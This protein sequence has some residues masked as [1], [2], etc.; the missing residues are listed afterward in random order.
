MKRKQFVRYLV[1]ISIVGLL[2]VIS[3]VYLT[4]QNDNEI[5]ND[6]VIINN[7]LRIYIA[8][9]LHYL[10]P[11][12]YGDTDSFRQMNRYGDGKYM[13]QIEVILDTF[14]TQVLEDKP[15]VVVL[16]GDLTLNGEKRSHEVLA[17]KLEKL[18]DQ[19]IAVYVIPGNHDI[20]SKAA[21][22][23]SKDTAVQTQS[24]TKQ[25]FR[26]IYEKFGYRYPTKRDSSLSYAVQ[27]SKN[28][29]LLMIDTNMYES[30]YEYDAS[31]IN[32]YVRSDTLRWIESELEDAKNTNSKVISVTHHNVLDHSERVN[33]GFTIDNAQALV[34]VYSKYGVSLNMSG[35]IHIQNISSTADLTDIA[36]GALSVSPHNYGV[37][38]VTNQEILDYEAV[39]L[40]THSVEGFAEASEAFFYDVS[41]RKGLTSLAETGES[42]AKAEILADYFAKINIAYFSGAWDKELLDTTIQ[43]WSTHPDTQFY[44]YLESIKNDT[45]NHLK[46]QSK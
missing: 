8:S 31:S 15:D 20:N 36:S 34:D 37:L 32:G 28:V 12:L 4:R 38:T 35:H 30:T 22:D 45:K 2:T 29:K 19:G 46:Y 42:K 16:S 1:V 13:P 27:I 21:Y 10:V 14:I 17:K 24:T 33:K 44:K 5:S 9:D 40:D 26:R 11:E 7:N 43:A 39:A 25:D 18:L 3:Y 23:Y 41:Y 6:D